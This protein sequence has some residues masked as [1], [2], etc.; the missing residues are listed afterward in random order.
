MKTQYVT[1]DGKV[2]ATKEDA[3]KYEAANDAGREVAVKEIIGK[4]EKIDAKIDALKEEIVKLLDEKDVLLKEWK[5][6]Y[7]T[8]EQKKTLDRIDNLFDYFFGKD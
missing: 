4:I 1:D 3:E 6:N 7:M 2:F 8:P 5:N